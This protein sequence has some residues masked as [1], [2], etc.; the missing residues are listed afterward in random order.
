MWENETP[1]LHDSRVLKNFPLYDYAKNLDNYM[2]K[3]ALED[4]Q[5]MNTRNSK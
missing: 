4:L 5:N 1:F 3:Q 2:S